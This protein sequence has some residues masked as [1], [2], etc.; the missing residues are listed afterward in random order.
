VRG[1]A[2]DVYRTRS[3]IARSRDNFFYLLCKTDSAWS[4]SQGDC[5]AR[6]LPGDAVLVD[7]RDRY[8][9]HFPVSADTV[10][11]E[12]PPAAQPPSGE[13][14]RNLMQLWTRLVKAK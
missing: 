11:L 9:F 7:S 3:A 1:S 6:L 12:L 13:V 2:Q 5:T 8:A 4:A 14:V 10:S